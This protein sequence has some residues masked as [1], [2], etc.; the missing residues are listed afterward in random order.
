LSVPVEGVPPETG[1]GLKVRLPVGKNAGAVIVRVSLATSVPRVPEIVAMTLE[2]TAVVL[3]GN[4]A[5]VCPE[6]TVTE[7]G[8]LA[9]VLLELMAIVVPALGAALEIVTVPWEAT[10]PL[11]VLGFTTSVSNLGAL[12]VIVSVAVLVTVAKADEIVA[13]TLALP[14]V[15]LIVKVAVDCPAGTVTLAGTVACALL[16]ESETIIPPEGALPERVTVPVA[17]VPP[18]TL[19]GA[20]VRLVRDGGLIVSVAVLLLL[21]YEVVI[22][23]FVTVATGVVLIVNVTLV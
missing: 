23:A 6:G 20:I 7:L 17:L 2:A 5:E 10:P 19:G 12:G 21:L 9:S 16:D 18:S 8:T 1:F 15:V 11:T 14:S 4:V 13:V 3:I 22:T